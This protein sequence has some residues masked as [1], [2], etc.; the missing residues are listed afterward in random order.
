MTCN[1][2]RVPEIAGPR[3]Q[4]AA[5]GVRMPT[6]GCTCAWCCHWVEAGPHHTR[7]CPNTAPVLTPAMRRAVGMAGTGVAFAVPHPQGPAHGHVWRRGG[8]FPAAR[9]CPRTAILRACF[10]K[11]KNRGSTRK[12]T[13]AGSREPRAGTGTSQGTYAPSFSWGHC[14]F[15]YNQCGVYSSSHVCIMR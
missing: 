1:D 3:L 10:Q 9:P 2:K 11:S 15:M 13:S 4:A 14:G 7:P 12:A 5:R 6:G 8:A